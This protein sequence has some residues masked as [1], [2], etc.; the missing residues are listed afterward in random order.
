MV[1]VVRR[2]LVEI[3]CKHVLHMRIEACGLVVGLEGRECRQNGRDK[4]E[5]GS[6]SGTLAAEEE[7]EEVDS[8]FDMPAEHTGDHNNNNPG[9]DIDMPAEHTPDHNPGFG[10]GNTQ[11]QGRTQD[12]TQDHTQDWQ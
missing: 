4:A 3:G 10:I 6:N 11:Q 9:F 1:V 5:G 7:E 12:H 8:S 2:R